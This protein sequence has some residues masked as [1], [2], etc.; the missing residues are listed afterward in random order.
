VFPDASGKMNLDL[1]GIPVIARSGVLV[2]SQFTLAADLRPGSA[3]GNR[4]SFTQAMSPSLA[5]A[6]VD[7]CVMQLRAGLVNVGHQVACGRFGADM[8]V[9][10]VNDGPVTLVLDSRDLQGARDG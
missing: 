9:A 8:A 5:S 6:L 7:A 10:L 2:V 1:A 4:P 3:K